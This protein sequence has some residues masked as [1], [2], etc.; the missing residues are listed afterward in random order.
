MWN[1]PSR[2]GTQP[3]GPVWHPAPPLLSPHFSPAGG[4]GNSATTQAR[5]ASEGSPG[6][7]LAC[8]SGLCGWCGM[9]VK[10]RARSNMELSQYGGPAG[11]RS[12][13]RTRA[14][15]RSE[16]RAIRLC[17]LENAEQ[18]QPELSRQ[19]MVVSPLVQHSN[20]P[21]VPR[22]AAWSNAEPTKPRAGSLRPHPVGVLLRSLSGA[23]GLAIASAVKRMIRA[24]TW[25]PNRVRA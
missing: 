1:T 19:F 12:G 3:G 21:T 14:A 15:W 7:S 20:E 2:Y 4:V 16:R 6:F 17:G 24:L 9:R 18:S 5:R 25:P 23:G 8:A 13:Q 11:G 22:T 10:A